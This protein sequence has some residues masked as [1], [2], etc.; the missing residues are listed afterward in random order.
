MQEQKKQLVK[1]LEMEKMEIS[2]KFLKEKSEMIRK[3]EE[4]IQFFD[5][6]ITLN[7]ER[8]I[9]YRNKA[10]ALFKQGKISYSNYYVEKCLKMNGKD[11][12]GLFLKGIEPLTF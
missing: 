9:F 1:K 4:E 6:A 3:Y 10:F 11:S 8:E 5:K 7:P 12:R 2:E